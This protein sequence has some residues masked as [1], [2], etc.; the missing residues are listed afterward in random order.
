VLRAVE[1]HAHSAER[2]VAAAA[3]AGWTLVV[4]REPAVGPDV[5]AFYERAG[6]TERYQAQLGLPL[7]LLLAFER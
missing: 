5:R 2:H 1:H 6:L 4:Q 7:V 3:S